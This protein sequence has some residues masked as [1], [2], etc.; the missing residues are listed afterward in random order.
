M[1]LTDTVWLITGTAPAPRVGQATAKLSAA[2]GTRIVI[3]D[4]DGGQAV[5]AAREI[6]ES[7]RGLACIVTDKPARQGAADEV[8]ARSGRIDVL[9]NT[10]SSGART[11]VQPRV[12]CPARGKRWPG[13]ALRMACR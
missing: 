6:G 1:L 10:A 9:V 2:H 3:P 8:S 5:F 12:G 11:T 7:H 4:L 13:N